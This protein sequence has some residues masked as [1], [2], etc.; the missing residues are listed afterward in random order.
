MLSQYPLDNASSNP[1]LPAYPE[2]AH[3]FFSQFTNASLDS[4]L[5]WPATELCA[6]R[7]G[8]GKSC[9]HPLPDDAALELGEH[10]EH[11]KHRPSRRR[12]GIER[13]LMQIK[14]ASKRPQ[15]RQEPDQILKAAAEPI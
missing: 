8:P 12:A 9:I 3:A 14:I 6:L 15:L 4:W 11:L 7:L 2:N 13:L 10:A 1:E 5:H